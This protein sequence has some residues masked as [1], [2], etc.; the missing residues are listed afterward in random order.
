MRILETQLDLLPV[1]LRL[2][3]RVKAVQRAVRLVIQS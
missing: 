2:T 3:A 1:R